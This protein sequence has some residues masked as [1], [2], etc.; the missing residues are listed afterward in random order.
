MKTL[1]KNLTYLLYLKPSQYL[2][3]LRVSK[4]LGFFLICKL[5]YP[6]K[7]YRFDFVSLQNNN[8]FNDNYL[9]INN[10]KIKIYDNWLGGE[11][12]LSNFKIHYF[13]YI[14]F[15]N[16]NT[17]SRILNNWLKNKIQHQSVSN[18]PY[19]ISRRLINFCIYFNNNNNIDIRNNIFDIINK[20]YR[21]LIFNLEYKLGTNH[22]SSNLT[23]IYLCLNIFRNNFRTSL[24]NL[25]FS[26]HIQDQI[27][28]DGCH[29]EQTPM[30]HSLFLQD[31]V[32]INELNFQIKY[33]D[34]ILIKCLE[35]VNEFNLKLNP[36]KSE[37]SFFNDTNNSYFVNSN[38]ISSFINNKFKLYNF[39]N[40]KKVHFQKF[41]SGFYF[42]DFENFKYIFF[43]S[44]IIAKFNPGHIHSGLL[45]FELY[46]DDKK[47]ITNLGISNYNHGMKRLFQKSDK[48]KNT[49]YLNRL[50]FGIYKSFRVNSYPE[51][52][53]FF[54]L[55]RDNY[56]FLSYYYV[57][58]KF[59]RIY[60]KK[61]IKITNNKFIVFETSNISH[62]HSYLNSN[63]PLKIIKRDQVDLL[64]Y[65]FLKFPDFGMKVKILRYKFLIKNFKSTFKII[66]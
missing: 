6:Q 59:K 18:H 3:F 64:N 20:D 52:K 7:F 53:K 46:I 11:D 10:K 54:Y 42:Y 29:I 5:K 56:F 66:F 9:K 27:L 26:K 4:I 44:E 63:V 62:F 49:A 24:F 39:Y 41:K 65:Q 2:G 40:S 8:F 28:D 31:L 48:T 21:K 58:G 45:P 32:L 43:N 55:S 36:G 25:Y 23:A 16:F 35:K 13:D 37:Y 17:F 50:S 47:I 60:Y 15:L 61:T 19:V 22:L 1:F 51:I 30:Y 57:I 12:L 33:K 14:H 34:S 38:K